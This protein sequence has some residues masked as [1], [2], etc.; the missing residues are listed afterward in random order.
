MENIADICFGNIP[1]QESLNMGPGGNMGNRDA[2]VKQFNKSKNKWKRD[3]KSLKNQNKMLYIIAKHTVSCK[4]L[5]KINNIH[6]NI[7]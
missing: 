2:A 4:E 3:M 1:D 6:A 5:N 7:A